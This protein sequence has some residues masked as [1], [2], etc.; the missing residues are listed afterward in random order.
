M[1][2]CGLDSSGLCFGR[3]TGCCEYGNEPSGPGNFVIAEK[4][5]AFQKLGR[6]EGGEL[7][8]CAPPPQAHI[9]I[10]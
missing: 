4:P 5:L 2:G 10:P 6:T 8:G 7:V 9:K 3:V 1:R